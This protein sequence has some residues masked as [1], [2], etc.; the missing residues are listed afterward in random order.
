VLV[1]DLLLLLLRLLHL[2]QQA[3][4]QWLLRLFH[5]Q[6]R[7]LLLPLW[8]LHLWLPQLLDQLLVVVV[9]CLLADLQH[10]EKRH[11]RCKNLLLKLTYNAAKKC[12][13]L[14]KNLLRLLRVL[15]LQPL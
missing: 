8:L 6:L 10:N 13:W 11:C 14:K 3:Q 7:L 2:L 9:A 1:L 4:H 15:M 12:D 5:R